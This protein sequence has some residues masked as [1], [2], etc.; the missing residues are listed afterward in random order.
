[1]Y[2]ARVH[3]DLLTMQKQGTGI[4]LVPLLVLGF[5]RDFF[6][7]ADLLTGLSLEFVRS[8]HSIFR[9]ESFPAIEADAF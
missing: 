1:M 7:S 4:M 6:R 9:I 3:A 2:F 5:F 8:F